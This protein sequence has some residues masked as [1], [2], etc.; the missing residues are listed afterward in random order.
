[1]SRIVISRVVRT[2]KI[3]LINAKLRK[4]KVSNFPEKIKVKTYV[5]SLFAL[6]TPLNQ[7]VRNEENVN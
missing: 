7:N 4:S 5:L 6:T 1:M 2:V 3:P